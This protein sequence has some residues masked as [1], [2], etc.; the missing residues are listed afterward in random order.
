MILQKFVTTNRRKG[1][2]ESRSKEGVFLPERREHPRYI[3]ELPI[4]YSNLD[5]KERWGIV[6][7]ASEGGLL[8]YLPEVIEKG[9]VLKIEIFFRRGSELNTIKA[10]AK[11]VWSDSI[12]KKIWGEY[13]Y[14]LAFQAFHKESLDKLINLLKDTG[15]THRA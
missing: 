14:G 15:E 6:A 13:K 8:A 5:G 2:I 10:M 1:E 9:S 7:D 11:V 4:D 12:D 3:L